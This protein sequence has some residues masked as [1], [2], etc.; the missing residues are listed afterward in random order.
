MALGVDPRIEALLTAARGRVGQSN[1]QRQQ[2]ALLAALGLTD[3]GLLERSNA[4]VA[5]TS[6][7]GFAE[8]PDLMNTTYGVQI[9]PQGRAFRQG[10]GAVDAS[11]AARGA[12]Y[13]TSRRN[14]RFQLTRE[15]NDQVNRAIRDFDARQSGT[16]M[17]QSGSLD[18]L[19]SGI[20]DIRFQQGREEAER[21]RQEAATPAPAAPTPR[22]PLQSPGS[23]AGRRIINV[24]TI[25]SPGQASA[26]ARDNPGYV[27]KRRGAKANVGGQPSFVLVRR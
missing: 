16:L 25:D 14:A 20:A 5:G 18:S 26:L 2:L 13:G 8:A 4:Q 6:A 3:S 7:A 12:G 17:D 9:G 11:A 15:L 21:R 22:N 24:G 1:A 27:L 19:A 10:L 23:Q